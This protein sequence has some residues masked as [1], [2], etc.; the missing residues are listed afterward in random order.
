MSGLLPVQP[1]PSRTE[2]QNPTLN[3]CSVLD[4]CTPLE[5][6]IQLTRDR[7][8][9]SPL[10][11]YPEEGHDVKNLPAA[12]DFAAR[13]IDWFESFMPSLRLQP[14][15]KSDAARGPASQ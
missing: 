9:I 15:R 7:D 6:T 3:I 13:V 8:V 10:M 2:D 11:V 4:R 5:E 14:L 1:G 12:I